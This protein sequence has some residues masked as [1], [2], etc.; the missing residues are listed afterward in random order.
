M[1]TGRFVRRH[2][3]TSASL[4]HGAKTDYDGIGKL[5]LRNKSIK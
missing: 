5:V 2:K 4:D 3:S 1:H